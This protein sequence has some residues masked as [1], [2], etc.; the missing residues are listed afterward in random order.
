[1][2]TKPGVPSGHR[3]KAS[4]HPLKIEKPKTMT[5]NKPFPFISYFSQVF[6]S[7]KE[8]TAMYKHIKIGAKKYSYTVSML[9]SGLAHPSYP[10][11][12]LH[13][14]SPALPPSTFPLKVRNNLRQEPYLFSQY[15]SYTV[16]K[17]NKL[18]TVISKCHDHINTI[19]SYL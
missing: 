13:L 1:M 19:L 16:K 14:D 2:D 17:S 6:P 7:M 11:Y 8:N 10:W 3:S 15:Q 9:V 12:M 18:Y 5:S 4:V